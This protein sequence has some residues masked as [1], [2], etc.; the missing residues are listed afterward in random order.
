MKPTLML[1]AA[2]KTPPG[3]PGRG[4]QPTLSVAALPAATG[5]QQGEDLTVFDKVR[6]DR[7]REARIVELDREVV[8]AF[9]GALWPGGAD[10]GAPGVDPM[11]GSIVVCPVDLGNDADAPALQAERDNL[12]LEL[13]AGL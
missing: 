8:A 4:L 12:A 7:S 13:V 10:L 6:V 5:P 9:A 2:E 11:A 1:R 3:G